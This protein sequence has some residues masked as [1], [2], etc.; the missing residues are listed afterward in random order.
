MLNRFFGTTC[1]R[2]GCGHRNPKGAQ[3]CER[4]NI[5]LGFNRPVILS[6]NRWSP[7]PD[8]MA[9]FFKFKALPGVFTKTLHVPPGMQAWL[10]QADGT[11]VAELPEGEYPVET[12][13]ERVNNFFRSSPGEVLLARTTQLPVSWQ[14]TDILCADLLAVQVHLTLQLRMGDLPSFRRHFMLQDGVV[15]ADSLRRLLEHPVRQVVKEWVAKYRMEEML[16][17][18]ARDSLSQAVQSGLSGVLNDMGLA[19]ESVVT[20]ELKHEAF[21]ALRRK[22]GEVQLAVQEEQ[23][24]QEQRKRFQEF[25]DA[26][27]RERLSQQAEELRRRQQAQQLKADEEALAQVL[28]QRETEECERILKAKTREEAIQ[29]G[30]ADEVA[31]LRHEHTLRQRQRTRELNQDEQKEESAEEEWR[32]IQALARI[33]RDSELRIAKIRADNAD[34]LARESIANERIRMDA[35]AELALAKL[36]QDQ[37]LARARS[38]AAVAEIYK[39]SLREQQLRDMENQLKIDGLKLEAQERERQS[40]RVQEYEDALTQ[41][42]I[43]EIRR[44]SKIADDKVSMGKL[45]EL[46]A[47]SDEMDLR[48]LERELKKRRELQALEDQQ[49]DREIDRKLRERT[50][51]LNDELKRGEVELQRMNVLGALPEGALVVLAES[52]A[53]IDALVK[54]HGLAQ[55]KEMTPE[56]IR[57]ISEK[58]ATEVSATEGRA[59][60]GDKAEQQ[61]SREENIYQGFMDRMERTHSEALKVIQDISKT[62]METTRDVGVAGAGGANSQPTRPVA[63]APAP[64]A[65]S[66]VPLALKTCPHCN[67]HSLANARLCGHCGTSF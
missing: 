14:F 28:R 18:Q 8:E 39:T 23:A 57:A 31:R 45:R 35:E 64:A 16:E 13:F 42:K 9:A 54:I 32:H 17:A 10:L 6:G 44:N 4:C 49:L 15:S 59:F 22:K 51:L 37:E 65:V 29:L 7:A 41:Q 43:E 36:E 19:M 62:A 26:R 60:A 67:T 34:I 63:P 56:Q 55:M 38:D 1:V 47:I 11:T 5:S 33:K 61:Q 25:Y 50:A 27:E 58:F 20:L 52:P 53:K 46:A 12:L 24:R 48:D 66:H 40:D 21:D 3:Y 2:P 30:A